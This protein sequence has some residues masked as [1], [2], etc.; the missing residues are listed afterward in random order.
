MLQSGP[1]SISPDERFQLQLLRLQA[2]LRTRL[3]RVHSANKAAV[4]ALRSAR[5]LFAA[6][7]AAVATKSAGRRNAEVIY[8][9]PKEDRWDRE[10]LSR[11]LAVD[12]P[13]IPEDILLA[14]V[15]RRGR[16][17]AV[18]ALRGER[19][20]TPDDRE[21]LFAITETLTEI[22]RSVD[23]ERTR[24]VRRKIERK[25]ADRQDPKDLIY[26]LLHGMRSLTRYDHSAALFLAREAREPLVL[27]A[28]QIAWTKAR[29][30]RIGLHLELD[31]AA[32]RELD[33]GGVR[34]YERGRDP[35]HG[36]GWTAPRGPASGEAPALPRLLDDPRPPA[37]P[38][39]AMLCAPIAT[40]GGAL[41]VLKIS[42]RR[43][44]VLGG[45]EARL[46]EDFLPLTSLTVQFLLHTE[47]LHEQILRSERKYALA[48]LTRGVTHDLNNALGAMLPLVQQMRADV[49]G[50]RLE[51]ETLAKDLE[52]IERSLQTCR[53]IFSGM[54]AIARGSSPQGAVQGAGHGNLRR[55]IDGA[56]S[57]LQDSL[58]RQAVAVTLE[59]PRE[60]PAIRGS[61]G[62]L[63]Q[64]FLNLFTNARDAMS[65]GGTL[66][67]VAERVDGAVEIEVKDDGAGIPRAAL[68][69]IS[70]PFFT[71]KEWGNGLGLSICRSIV[72]DIGGEMTVD[73]EE[74]AGTTVHL[75]LPVLAE[76]REATG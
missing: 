20:F 71:T 31:E 72:W 30:R 15:E 58:E 56:L 49:R 10:L 3:S 7:E 59:L 75:T 55:A 39:V 37:P 73:S 44:E 16:N 35:R 70:E 54:L 13:K 65:P 51:P 63:T 34:L 28:E 47:W 5:E 45:Y 14:P 23:E 57:V 21:A 12:R 69:R 67:V 64:V 25:I 62:D 53:R 61:Q 22:V 6:P 29:S 74:G 48:N 17:W 8:T 1:V 19:P 26:D 46:I 27:V 41:G 2:D 24:R 38:E 52:S 11:Y 68:D 18:L 40:P 36:D 76:E 33:R 4:Y 32:R 66:A 43:R 60:L 42:A 9:L 50:G